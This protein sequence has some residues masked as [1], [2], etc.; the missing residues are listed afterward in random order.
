MW[1]CRWHVPLG[2]QCNVDDWTKAARKPHGR[3][4]SPTADYWS[5]DYHV[6]ELEWGVSEAVWR[7]DGV[8]Y[9]SYPDVAHKWT[10]PLPTTAMFLILDTAVSGYVAAPD[11]AAMPVVHSVDWVSVQ[12]CL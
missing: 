11:P 4:D 9:Y 5:E 6:F 12:Q 10:A 2:T 3:F 8:P 7:V 1:S